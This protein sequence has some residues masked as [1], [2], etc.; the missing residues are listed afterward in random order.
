MLL[1]L[2]SVPFKTFLVFFPVFML[3]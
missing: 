3:D 1:I 2:F